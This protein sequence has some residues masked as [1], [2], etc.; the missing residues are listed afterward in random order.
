MRNE[1]LR[2]VDGKEIV[3]YVWD[4]VENP[5]AVLQ[6]C[7]G[8]CENL[9]RYDDFAR[10]MNSHGYIVIGD[11]HRG[12]GK[13]DNGS[14]WSEGEFV[15]STVIDLLILNGQ[16]KQKYPNLPVVFLGHSYGSLLGQRFVEFNTGIKACVLTGTMAMPRIVYL[17]GQILLWLPKLVLGK[18]KIALPEQNKA[19]EDNDV[20]HAWLTKDKEIRKAYAADP[21]S[22]G[23]AA[24]T[25]YY[26]MMKL[27]AR[28]GR[29]KSLKKIDKDL[30][31]A[32]YCGKDDTVGMM[33]K[34]P[35]KLAE[36]YT[37]LGIKTVDLKLYENDR[38]EVLNETDRDVVYADVLAF[39]DKALE[40]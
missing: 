30:P 39:F 6:L 1:T 24:I 33:G 28:A 22:G 36:R 17:L 27:L 5:K 16:I 29:R 26:G 2:S 11:D 38:H 25:F 7:H 21:L 31:I 13:T 37:G 3:I 8:M 23:K 12:Y 4:E 40:K 10:F 18:V 35:P 19:F 14:G 20:P 32:I 34:F 9:G 15:G